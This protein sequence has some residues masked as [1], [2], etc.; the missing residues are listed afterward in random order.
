V[1][2][3]KVT[4]FPVVLLGRSYWDGLYA[5]LADVLVAQGKLTEAELAL[6]HLTDDIDEAVR[7]VSASYQARQDTH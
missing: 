2:T 3:K 6:V 7:L 1:Q 4:K 5:W